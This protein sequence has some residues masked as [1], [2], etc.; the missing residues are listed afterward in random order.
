MVGLLSA[1]VAMLI[2]IKA[3]S[4]AMLAER[5]AKRSSPRSDGTSPSNLKFSNVMRSAEGVRVY[6]KAASPET[7]SFYRP[8][9][10][11]LLATVR[12]LS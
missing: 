12:S 8:N 4:L 10:C 1:G 3:K 9:S 7:I 5:L 11:G 6:L 2:M